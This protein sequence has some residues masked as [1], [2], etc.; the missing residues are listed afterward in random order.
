MFMSIS[1][2]TLKNFALIIFAG[3][4]V[5]F[6]LLVSNKLVKNLSEEEH[7]K[8]DLWAKGVRFL[9]TTQDSCQDLTFVSEVIQNN[10]TLPVLLT[11]ESGR[12]ISHLNISE[13]QIKDS[14]AVYRLLRKMTSEHE[15]IEIMLS[16][17]TKNYVYYRDSTTL[18]RL[19]FFP[20]IQIVIIL[21]FFLISYYA[22]SQSRKAH[23]NSIW[24]GMAKETAH[25]LGTPTSSLMG[26]L[27]L[28]EEKIPNDPII[29]ELE[30]D[31]VRL[32]KIAGRFSKIGSTPILQEA[33][34]IELLN[35]TIDYLGARVLKN[36]TVIKKYNVQEKLNIRMN[37][38]LIEWVIENIVKNSA[39]AMMGKGE[40]TFKVTDNT[41]VVFIDISDTGR[42]IQKGKF[43]EIFRAGFTTKD[44]GW[45]LGLTLSKRIIEQHHGGKIFV[46]NSEPGFGTTFRIV[47]KKR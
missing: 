40:I 39:D 12:I 3:F 27:A 9:S 38:I 11:D 30:K 16:D 47:L 24:Y 13:R 29:M 33:N 37:G 5:I 2:N 4:I 43:E 34:L 22:Y 14:V 6:S 10:R 18:R 46:L 41:Q 28:L 45:G 25:Q 17:S 21:L 26:C 31:I 7:A 23:E 35:S 42:G 20:Y 19:E 36:V 44:R 32:E 1:G 15:P 8:I